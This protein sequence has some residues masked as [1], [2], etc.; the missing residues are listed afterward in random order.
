MAGREFHAGAGVGDPWLALGF[1]G[2]VS[3]H[4]P[5]SGSRGP[6]VEKSVKKVTQACGLFKADAEGEEDLVVL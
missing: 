4:T 1:Q 6:V 2:V 3:L 5:T